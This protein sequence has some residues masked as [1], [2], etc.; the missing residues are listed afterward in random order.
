MTVPFKNGRRAV[1][2]QL[3]E[4]LDELRTSQGCDD[5]TAGIRCFASA[6]SLL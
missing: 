6:M 4:F 1:E 2:E 3:V 5:E